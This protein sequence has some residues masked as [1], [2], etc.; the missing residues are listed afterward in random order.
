MACCAHEQPALPALS[1]DSFT[2]APVDPRRRAAD[3]SAYRQMARL[4]NVLPSFLMVFVGAFCAAH[5]WRVAAMPAV[6]AMAAASA[7]IAVS[8]V[9][10]ND[11]FDFVQGVDAV[12]APDKPLPRC[13]QIRGLPQIHAHGIKLFNTE[14]GT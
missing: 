4:H 1:A 6:W 8:S 10:V 14:L 11:Y 7:G 9:V 13:A 3:F 5:T 2:V 12:N